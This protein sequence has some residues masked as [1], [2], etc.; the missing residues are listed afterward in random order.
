MELLKV[1]FQEFLE[2]VEGVIPILGVDRAAFCELGMIS[3]TNSTS[4]GNTAKDARFKVIIQS[5]PQL[6]H[7]AQAGECL[8]ESKIAESTKD[9][10]MLM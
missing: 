8:N 6:A 2:G 3:W 7:G 1:V 5:S 10:E 9:T 4:N